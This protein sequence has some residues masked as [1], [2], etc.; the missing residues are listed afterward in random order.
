VSSNSWLDFGGDPDHEADTGILKEFLPYRDRVNSTRFANNPRSCRRIF[1]MFWRTGCPTSNKPF[2]SG[3]DLH[4]DSDLGI[5]DGSL[6]LR[7]RAWSALPW[8][9]FTVSDCF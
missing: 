8:R 5:F 9:R 2:Y 3:A 4:G 7:D 1:T 6:Q